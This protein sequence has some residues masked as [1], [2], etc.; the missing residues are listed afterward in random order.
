M[1]LANDGVIGNDDM[2][3]M[4]RSAKKRHSRS[5]HLLGGLGSGMPGMVT[6]M[7]PRDRPTVSI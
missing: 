5:G 2:L 6:T 4:G 1:A 3:E 7:K